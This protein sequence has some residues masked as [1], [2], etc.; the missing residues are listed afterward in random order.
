[1]LTWQIENLLTLNDRHFRRYEPE[2]ITVA[3]P[4][5]LLSGSS[6]PP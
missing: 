5:D 4:N 6:T 2:G 1:M 3:T